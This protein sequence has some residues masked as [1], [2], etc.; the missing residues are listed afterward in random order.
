MRNY[1]RTLALGLVAAATFVPTAAAAPADDDELTGVN[2]GSVATVFG[3]D[4]SATTSA[5]STGARAFVA[6]L[7]RSGAAGGSYATDQVGDSFS[8]FVPTPAGT[9]DLDAPDGKMRTL[10]RSGFAKPTTARYVQYKRYASKREAM[11]RLTVRYFRNADGELVE[12]RGWAVD[13]ATGALRRIALADARSL[14]LDPTKGRA[15]TEYV[16]QV[17]IKP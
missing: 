2:A 1:R 13:I 17:F 3:A 12:E 4:G 10:T 14:S 8:A 6:Q 16:Y 15:G 9:A 11:R 7:V 5:A